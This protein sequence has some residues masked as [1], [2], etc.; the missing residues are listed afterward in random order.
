MMIF[1]HHLSFKM[2]VLTFQDPIFLQKIGVVNTEFMHAFDGA[3]I[4]GMIE[5]HLVGLLGKGITGLIEYHRLVI[6]FFE[7]FK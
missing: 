4:W 3:L 7:E 1:I 2:P 5:R 6:L